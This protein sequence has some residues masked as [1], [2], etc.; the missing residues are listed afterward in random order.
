VRRGFTLVELLVVIAILAVLA[1]ILFPVF[2]RAREKA[3]Q[4]SC[5]SNMRQI[6]IAWLCYLQ[7]YDE[8]GL[9]WR[10]A[11][12]GTWSPHWYYWCDM[13]MP[14]I[15]NEQILVC[16]S[17]NLSPPPNL[18]CERQGET[19]LSDY[20]QFCWAGGTGTEDDAYY[21]GLDS[22]STLAQVTRPSELVM[23]TEG[24]TFSGPVTIESGKGCT[25]WGDCSDD[26][27]N[28]G[29]CYAFVD[30]HSKWMR[31]E[32]GKKAVQVDGLWY[33]YYEYMW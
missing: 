26:R 22:E 8:R 23:L 24:W 21:R 1:A 7:D 13:L 31:P 16:P 33:L 2:A 6:G 15:R 27:H 10:V 18:P 20:C 5:L 11:G 3:R 4:T 12:K 25:G 9:N 32:E 28:G 29:A 30:G 19:M 14:Y 17:R